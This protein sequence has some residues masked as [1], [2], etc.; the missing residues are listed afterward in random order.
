MYILT[1]RWG[2]HWAQTDLTRSITINKQY[3]SFY[4]QNPMLYFD[5][6]CKPS[7]QT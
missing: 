6:E 5:R 3:L 4:S 7:P 2:N 1:W